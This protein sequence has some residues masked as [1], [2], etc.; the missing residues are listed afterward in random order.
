M[1]FV[2]VGM[3]ESGFDRLVKAAD[4]LT[5]F[6]DEKV[7]IQSGTAA[8]TPHYAEYF[9]FAAYEVIEA[10]IQSARVVV[11]QAGAGTIIQVLKNS[12]PLVA[13]PRFKRYGENHNDHQLQLAQAL[14]T[15]GR[16]VVLQELTGALLWAA[17][18]ATK[19]QNIYAGSRS[20]LVN[21][22][23]EQINIW[24]YKKIR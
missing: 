22:L 3:H 18:Q 20:N 24:S 13:V 16:A 7:V 15:Q 10:K 21:A 19:T 11:C 23:R 17:V 12:K 9:E 8:Y 2:T 5:T 1:I 4:E 14:H 6:T